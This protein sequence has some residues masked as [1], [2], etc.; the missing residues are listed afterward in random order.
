MGV[1]PWTRL[2]L[3]GVAAACVLVAACAPPP[4][5]PG[6]SP[7]RP[8]GAVARPT[9]GPDLDGAE[10]V[11]ALRES[12]LPVA[13]ARAFTPDTDPEKSLGR[14]NQ[15]TVKV[16]WRDTR[17]AGEATIELFP[18]LA[19]LE[20]RKRLTE[21]RNLRNGQLAEYIIERTARRALLRLPRTLTAE[22]LHEYEDWLS[23]L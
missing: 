12:G 22:Q 1:R 11:L 4:T 8:P 19:S 15:Y 9:L 10:V 3:A 23:R 20:A 5:A 2:F 13:D 16:S 14:P 21:S 7:T 17:A 18:T 6:P